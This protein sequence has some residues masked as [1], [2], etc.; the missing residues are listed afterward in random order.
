MYE[1]KY[2]YI[3][4]YICFCIYIYIYIYIYTLIYIYIYIYIYNGSRLTRWTF[5]SMTNMK[6][7]MTANFRPGLM[8]WQWHFGVA[9]LNQPMFFS[10]SLAKLQRHVKYRLATPCVVFNIHTVTS[11]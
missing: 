11:V 6:A 10:N 9:K 5:G 1:Y 4:I 8:V 2:I 3:Y 7:D